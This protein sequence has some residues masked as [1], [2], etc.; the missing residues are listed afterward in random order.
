M[1]RTD[2]LTPERLPEEQPVELSLRPRRLSEFIGQEKAR[3]NL[4]VF[5]EAARGELALCGG[6]DHFVKMRVVSH[7]GTELNVEFVA[8][9]YTF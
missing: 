6:D 4:S 8:Y 9:A 2:E 5:I 1:N 3:A 7:T